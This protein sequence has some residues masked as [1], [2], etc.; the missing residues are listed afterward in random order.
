MEIR[1]TL[2]VISNVRGGVVRDAD[3]QPDYR[4]VSFFNRGGMYDMEARVLDFGIHAE[5]QELVKRRVGD[6][7]DDG[8]E[9]SQATE[10]VEEVLKEE[11]VA[12]GVTPVCRGCGF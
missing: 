1:Q 9:N 8:G 12:L 3:A 7:G 11:G 2:G 6:A 10:R 4:D 5:V